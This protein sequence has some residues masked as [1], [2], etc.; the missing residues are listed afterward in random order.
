MHPCFNPKKY[1]ALAIVFIG[2]LITACVSQ[3]QIQPGLQPRANALQIGKI[4]AIPPIIFPH[5]RKNSLID[6]ATLESSPFLAD[7]ETSV[8]GAFQNQP[9]VNG[10]SFNAVRKQLVNNNNFF[11]FFLRTLT[12]TSQF[13]NFGSEAERRTFSSSCLNSKDMLDFY[14]HCIAPQKQWQTKLNQLSAKV[15][16]ADAALFVLVQKLEK[17][18]ESAIR[19]KDYRS[20]LGLSLLLVDTNSGELLWGKEQVIEKNQ[21][22]QFPDL[23]M[24]AK[25]ILSEEFWIN[26]PGRDTK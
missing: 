10:V 25:D 26:F 11:D 22:G 12:Q 2:T 4:V 20:A 15:F 9:R 1:A 8:L 5:P 6:R 14:E 24:L 19:N 17:Q 13:L 18:K 3:V 21:E 23:S 7:L 16:L